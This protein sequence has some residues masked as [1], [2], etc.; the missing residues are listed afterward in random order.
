MIGWVMV[1]MIFFMMAFNIYITLYAAIK[2]SR[3]IAIKYYKRISFYAKKYSKPKKLTY[4][5][6]IEIT[7]NLKIQTV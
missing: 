6:Q 1:S 7:D 5:K 2:Y 3:L 4:V